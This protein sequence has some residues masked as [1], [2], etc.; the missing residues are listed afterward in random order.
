[1]H[2]SESVKTAH[3][4]FKSARLSLH[5]PT[6]VCERYPVSNSELSDDSSGVGPSSSAVL[7]NCKKANHHQCACCM[8]H[9][10]DGEN[11][12]FP[13]TAEAD[14]SKNEDL[15]VSA[16]LGRETSEGLHQHGRRE[17]EARD[18]PLPRSQRP[19]LSETV[20]NAL[21]PQHRT[22]SSV[23]LHDLWMKF[24]ERQKA[25]QHC[26]FRSNGELTLVE[27]LD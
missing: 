4:V 12:F 22:H 14:Y 26:D 2:N 23:S 5:H 6:P 9:K 10:K 3:S 1:T 21:P 15:N 11:K 18:H 7:Q 13:L 8:P 19:H 20:E 25:H 24:L 17:A 16:S 27:R